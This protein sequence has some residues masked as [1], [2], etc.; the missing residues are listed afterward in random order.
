MSESLELKLGEITVKLPTK[1]LLPAKRHWELL[2]YTIDHYFSF[3]APQDYSK[4]NEEEN[5]K[6]KTQL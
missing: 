4:S 5:N 6:E 1:E 3:A 2:K